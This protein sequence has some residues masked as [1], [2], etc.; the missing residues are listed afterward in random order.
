MNVAGQ[1]SRPIGHERG[2]LAEPIGSV[3]ADRLVCAECDAVY[4]RPAL[5]SDG[6]LR[7]RR[8]GALLARGHWLAPDGQLAL[9]VACALVYAIATLSPI[10]TLELRGVDSVATLWEATRLTW[11]AGEHLVAVLAA[12]TVI[13]F[14]LIVILLRL[15]ILAP[16]VVG[17]RAPGLVPALHA[18]R[19][20]TRWSMVEVFMLAVLIAVV[21]SAGVTNVV[22]GAGIFAYGM[23]AVLLAAVQATGLEGLWRQIRPPSS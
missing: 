16:M 1:T 11:N 13:V 2:P 9:S 12:A 20:T 21:R 3:R 4:P 19:W 6:L 22:L 14:P 15:W 23:L 5:A 10:V 8:C 18:L 7:C 17:R